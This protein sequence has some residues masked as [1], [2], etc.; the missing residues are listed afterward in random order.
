MHIAIALFSLWISRKYYKASFRPQ[1]V[2]FSQF[3]NGGGEDRL[4]LAYIIY[5]SFI[6]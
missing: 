4:L 3:I 2:E 1:K 5:S 6:L